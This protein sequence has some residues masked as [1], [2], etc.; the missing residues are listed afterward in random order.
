MAK[1]VRLDQAP[2]TSMNPNK[3]PATVAAYLEAQQAAARQRQDTLNKYLSS[4]AVSNQGYA[5]SNQGYAVS[6]Q[7]YARPPVTQ[8]DLLRQAHA[9]GMNY[10]QMKAF[11]PR[12]VVAS[13]GG[14]NGPQTV[15]LTKESSSGGSSRNNSSSSSSTRNSSSS[16]NGST[17]P[18]LVEEF[19][20]GFKCMRCLTLF[21]TRPEL[22]YHIV[23]VHSDLLN[24]KCGKCGEVFSKQSKLEKH[25]RNHGRDKL[26]VCVQCD[27][28]FYQL[29]NLKRHEK[30][31]VVKK[32]YKCSG[33]TR[34]YTEMEKLVLHERIHKKNELPF[35]CEEENCGEGFHA[36]GNLKMHIRLV[37]TKKGK[38]K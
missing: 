23:K 15:D 9:G 12:P 2:P 10:N 30:T 24:F 32:T 33:C 31:H 21:P 5:V 35:Q 26:Y 25:E 38:K 11:G 16:R 3:P 13:N 6:N 18:K 22:K 29:E 14:R 1:V 17:G 19:E 27:S 34:T 20:S 37:H 4:S 7:G 28:S 8:F 36:R